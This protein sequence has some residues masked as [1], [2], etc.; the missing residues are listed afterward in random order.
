MV[1]C[2]REHA[3]APELDAIDWAGKK[4]ILATPSNVATNQKV[5]HDEYRLATL[6][7]QRRADVRA[8]RMRSTD[9][10]R[11][12]LAQ[13]EEVEEVVPPRN[14]REV[15]AA[16]KAARPAAYEQAPTRRALPR[17]KASPA[18]ERAMP[19]LRK[20]RAEQVTKEVLRKAQRKRIS[21]RTLYRAMKEIRKQ[22]TE[23]SN[24][25]REESNTPH[26]L[27]L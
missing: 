8:L 20:Q 21:P 18:L 4:V 25:K 5:V 7:R 19:W 17:K 1:K 13:A 12:T 14:L 16:A 6:L 10:R 23:E 22:K 27:Q 26:T 2:G 24:T 9:G 15:R 11:L 3:L